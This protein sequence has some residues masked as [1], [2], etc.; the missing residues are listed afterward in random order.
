QRQARRRAQRLG[1]LLNA[2][3]ARRPRLLRPT[4]R[5]GNRAQ[6]RPQAAGQPARRDSARLPEDP[7]QLPRGNRLGPPGKLPPNLR[8]S[9]TPKLLGCLS[10]KTGTD[11][12][13]AGVLELAGVHVR[14]H[15][16]AQPDH[17]V[18]GS[19]EWDGGRP[20]TCVTISVARSRSLILRLFDAR[21]S[22]ANAWSASQRDS[23]MMMPIARSITDRDCKACSS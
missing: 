6:R 20:R 16:A 11:Q 13:T 21:L 9:L 17:G 8:S 3:L 4:A 15:A 19:T 18:S 10:R 7:H 12:G 1:L 2:Q 23:A 14:A 5:Q 22:I